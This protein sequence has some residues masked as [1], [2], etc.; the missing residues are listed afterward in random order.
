MKNARYLTFSLFAV[1]AILG[2]VIPAQALRSISALK[3][4]AYAVSAISFDVP[5]P[6]P[7]PW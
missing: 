2:T 7:Y 3:V 1:L 4:A 5:V 6:T